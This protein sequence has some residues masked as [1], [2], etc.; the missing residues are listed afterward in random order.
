MNK[1]QLINRLSA[2]TNMQKKEC[3][4]M[5]DAM[6]DMMEEELHTTGKVQLSGFGTFETKQRNARQGVHPKSQEKITIPASKTVQFKLGKSLKGK[7]NG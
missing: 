7:L 5:V 1:A 4:L 2:Q 6:L 3:R